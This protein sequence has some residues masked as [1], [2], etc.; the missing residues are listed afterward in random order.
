MTHKILIFYII[1]VISIFCAEDYYRLLGVSRQA[2]KQEIRR[3]FKKLALKYHPDKN[4]DKSEWAKNQ[5]AKI[6]NAYE[7]LSDEEKRKVYDRHGEEGVQEHEQRKGQGQGS[8]EDLFSQFFGG[9][10]GGGF[11]QHF[12][13]QE[14]EEGQSPFSTSDVIHIKME[15][16]SRLY[17]R[18]EIWF[19]FFYKKENEEKQFIELAKTFAEK[20]YGIFKV[21]AVNCKW[22]E[23]I[24]DE[25]SVRETPLIMYF[26]ENIGKEEEIYR[27]NKRWEDIF[28]FG[29][30]NMESFVRVINS[31]NYEDFSSESN[32]N[33]NKVILFNPRKFT[34]P[35]FKALS[36]HFKGKLLFGEIRQSDQ[37]MVNKFHIQQFP[38]IF[39][40]TEPENYGGVLYDGPL[41]K[42]TLDK[43][44]SQY[45]YLQ[46]KKQMT[47][48]VKEMNNDSYTK[49]KQCN[50]NDSNICV[51]FIEKNNLFLSENDNIILNDLAKKY[52]NDPIR[53]YYVIINK[54]KN[55]WV[56]FDESSRDSNFIVIKGKRRR[57]YN[58][59]GNADDL[60]KALDNIIG[61]G[62][63]FKTLIVKLNFI[64][65][66][67]KKDL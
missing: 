34:P 29:S 62:G 35:L 3:A 9:G 1:L 43:F 30:K 51:I 2:S 31:G 39:V 5:F 42:D 11:H 61:G 13:Q 52:L 18:Q 60:E 14:E 22:D 57:Y 23:E 7:V 47:A 58:F 40:L 27:G 38:S 20:S 10:G 33:L 15:N 32:S 56:S 46:V 37:E 24:C 65:N 59:N 55:F 53:F 44:L 26:L 64:S 67:E 21:A 36:K 54:Y 63:D 19:V 45:A 12:H 49:H 41:K 25:F 8:G 48:P 28:T 50:D 6:A 4:K 17:R 16:L 66:E